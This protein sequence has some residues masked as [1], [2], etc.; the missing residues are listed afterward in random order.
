MGEG[1]KRMARNQGRQVLTTTFREN[2][3]KM[4]S[5]RKSKKKRGKIKQADGISRFL[6]LADKKLIFPPVPNISAKKN[7]F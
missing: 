3:K 1:R 6:I 7:Y 5:E 2:M 4:N